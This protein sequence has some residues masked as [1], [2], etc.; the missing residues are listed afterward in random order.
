MG[1][2]PDGS[3]QKPNGEKTVEGAHGDVILRLVGLNS[4]NDSVARLP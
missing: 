2:D 1:Q 4:H 3:D